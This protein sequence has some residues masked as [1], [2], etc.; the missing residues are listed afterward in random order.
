MEHNTSLPIFPTQAHSTSTNIPIESTHSPSHIYSIVKYIDLWPLVA[1][2]LIFVC[3]CSII[4]ACCRKSNVPKNRGYSRNA[5]IPLTEITNAQSSTKPAEQRLRVGTKVEVYSDSKDQWLE[6][7]IIK[8][9]N[10]LICIGYGTQE[11][12]KKWLELTSK[13]YRPKQVSVQLCVGSP[14]EV[15]SLSNDGWIDGRLVAIKNDLIRVAYGKGLKTQKWL[16][17]DS[18]QIRPKRDMLDHLYN[19][20]NRVVP[21]GGHLS[22]RI[23]RE[24]YEQ[25]PQQQIDCRRYDMGFENH[26][27]CCDVSETS[28]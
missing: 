24:Q 28:G 16:Y 15:Y 27:S 9:R 11:Q 18:K 6:G 7:T 8:M 5:Y 10:K 17:C 13:H 25:D 1:E 19:A 20:R 21:S 4:L 12:T 22:Y 3:L 2:I 23:R 14:V 26:D